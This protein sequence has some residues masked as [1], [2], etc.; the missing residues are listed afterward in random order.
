MTLGSENRN[1][2]MCQQE[3]YGAPDNPKDMHVSVE[4]NLYKALV[5]VLDAFPEHPEDENIQREF[6]YA[7]RVLMNAD[8]ARKD[9]LR[10]DTI[11]EWYVV[12]RFD[13]SCGRIEYWNFERR[14]FDEVLLH[15]LSFPGG[16]VQYTTEDVQ[17]A[18]KLVEK[19]EHSH[20]RVIR[21]LDSSPLTEPKV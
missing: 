16:Y 20:A 10:K 13:R 7:R 6:T 9:A 1:G 15:E 8:R 18:H 12:R 4:K 17:R 14:A 5:R 19:F 11:A 21:V 3:A 2:T